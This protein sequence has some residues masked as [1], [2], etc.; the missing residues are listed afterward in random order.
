MHELFEMAAARV[1]DKNK[2]YYHG[3]SKEASALGIFKYGLDPEYTEIKYAG[4]K[5]K[6]NFKPQE[7][8]VYITPDLSYAMIY[9]IGGDYAGTDCTR[10]IKSMGQYGFVFEISGSDIHDIVPDE[11]SIGEFISMW[12]D[13]S[14]YYKKIDPDF[15]KKESELRVMNSVIGL[16]AKHLTDSQYRK[17]KDGEAE[18]WAKAGKK[19]IPYMSDEMKLKIIDL[20]AHVA[21]H[22]NIKPIKCYRFDRADVVNMKKDGSNFFDYAKEWKP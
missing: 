7:N 17:V 22:G 21:H 12:L 1:S 19:L 6:S 10:D 2:A 9:G 20:G 16:A 5:K 13:D 11:D 14:G 4:D 18:Y 8:R 15:F 3:T